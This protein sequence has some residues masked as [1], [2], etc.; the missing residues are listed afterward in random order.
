MGKIRTKVLGSEEEKEQKQKDKAR[1]EG[2]KQREKKEKPAEEEIVEEKK[3]AEVKVKKSSEPAPLEETEKEAKPIKKEESKPKKSAG[4]QYLKV[5]TFVDRTKKYPLSEAVKL[6]KKTSYTKFDGTVEIH[7]NTLEK[8]LRGTVALPHG[9]GKTIRIA[10]ASDELIKEIETGKINFDILIST[11]QMM[12]KLAKVA[13]ILGP[14]GLMPNP[15]SGTVTAEPDKLKE[16][17]SHGQIQYRSESDFPIIHQSIGKVSF[18]ESQLEEN[19]KAIIEAVGKKNIVSAS[20][21][22]TMGP[23]IKI[24]L[25]SI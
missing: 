20:L 7:I 15:K 23:G 3:A 2:K 25:D 4:R 21:N 24:S 17:L 11:P 9:T 8:G 22:C 10:E 18:D 14:K 19:I 16:K 12:P 5:K 1:R 6:A 13:K